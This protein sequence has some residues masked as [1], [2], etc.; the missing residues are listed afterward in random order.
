MEFGLQLKKLR[1]LSI[2]SLFVGP[3]IYFVL[4]R[5]PCNVLFHWCLGLFR[6]RILQ[7]ST[8]ASMSV[9]VKPRGEGGTL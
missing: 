3:P 8:L 4:R 1:K 5:W 7:S 2:E 6:Q 9:V